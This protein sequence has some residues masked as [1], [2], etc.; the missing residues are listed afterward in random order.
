MTGGGKEETKD[1]PKI[2]VGKGPDASSPASPVLQRKFPG[3]C[4]KH[5]SVYKKMLFHIFLKFTNHLDS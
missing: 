1:L 2:Q 4:N 5:V 3:I